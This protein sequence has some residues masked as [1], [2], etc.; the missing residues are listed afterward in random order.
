MA[1]D[2][3]IFIPSQNNIV[4]FCQVIMNKMTTT[5][6]YTTTTMYY[7]SSFP[8]SFNCW[9]N[10]LG[11][12]H[13]HNTQ[14][15][16]K[17]SYFHNHYYYLYNKDDR[18]ESFFFARTSLLSVLLNHPPFSVGIFVLFSSV[19][20]S[21]S[22]GILLLRAPQV[23][24]SSYNDLQSSISQT[25]STDTFLDTKQFLIFFPDCSD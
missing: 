25:R 18:E 2:V 24:Y 13:P 3:L 4:F 14:K 7:I 1:S 23:D 21:C 16:N 19:F 9:A 6:T 20:Y 11:K 15:P 10:Q 12:E 5:T 8:I 17:L 22:D